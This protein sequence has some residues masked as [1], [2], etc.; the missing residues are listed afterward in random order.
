[1]KVGDG[2]KTVR[3]RSRRSRYSKNITYVPFDKTSRA[4][5]PVHG[6]VPEPEKQITHGISRKPVGK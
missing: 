2:Q 1:M 3:R 6:S 5:I 4:L